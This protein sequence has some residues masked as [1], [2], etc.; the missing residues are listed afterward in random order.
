[1][2]ERLYSSLAG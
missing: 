2:A 1:M